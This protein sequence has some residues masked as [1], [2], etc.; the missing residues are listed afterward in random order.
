MKT[1]KI[2][3][4]TGLTLASFVTLAGTAPGTG[5]TAT[6]HDWSATSGQ[7]LLLW[8][9]GAKDPVTGIL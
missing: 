3:V 5:I 6:K 2:M 4:A 9:S 1:L 7:T 8:Q